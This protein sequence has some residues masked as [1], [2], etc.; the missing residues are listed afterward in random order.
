MAQVAEENVAQNGLADKLAVKAIRSTAVSSLG[1][2]KVAGGALRAGL[3]VAEILDAGLLGE[4]CLPT[5]RHA[6]SCLLSPNYFAV[7][8]SAEIC[9][10]CVESGILRSWQS[11]EGSWWATEAFKSDEGDANPHDVVLERLVGTGEARILTEEFSALSF[12]FESLPPEAGRCEVVSLKVGTAGWLDAVV[13]WWYCVMV[14]NDPLPTMTN[15]PARVPIATRADAM[16]GRSEIGHWRQAVSILPGPRRFLE[17]GD[18]LRMAVFHTDEDIWFRVVEP[19]FVP[20]PLALP[21]ASSSLAFLPATRL[22]SMADDNRWQKLERAVKDAVGMLQPQPLQE[23]G[24]ILVL[25]LSDGPFI[26]LILARHLAKRFAKCG[27]SPGPRSRH[28]RRLLRF[29][30]RKPTVLSFESSEEGLSMAMDVLKS[31]QRHLWRPKYCR[32][33][34]VLGGPGLAPESVAMI[35]AEPYSQQCEGLP[36]DAHFWQHWAQVDALRWTLAPQA[37]LVPLG[38]RVQVALISCAG[39]WQRRQPVTAEVH[40]VNVS[41]INKLHPDRT[42]KQTAARHRFPC[43]LWQIEHQVVSQPITLCQV[44]FAADFPRKLLRCPEVR[45]Q[46]VSKDTLVHGLATWTEV[47]VGGGQWLSTAPLRGAVGTQQFLPTPGMQGVLL[48]KRPRK[49]GVGLAPRIHFRT[50][51]WHRRHHLHPGN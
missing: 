20:K 34:P 32:I 14:R 16:A 25:D 21:R 18:K 49:P 26:S 37:V 47:P 45:L 27:G 36:C 1:D 4:D 5:L 41:Q 50:W 9:A 17:A 10:C 6:A 23:H 29:A 2:L 51:F 19:S 44:S 7:P 8:A 30:G 24:G 22:W 33:R 43:S 38:F 13:F 48:A 42:F 11:V 39:L 3:L 35:C 15:A 40:G 28:L 12:N 31:G 46:V